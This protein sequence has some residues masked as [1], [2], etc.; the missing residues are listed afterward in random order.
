MD[1]NNKAYPTYKHLD[2]LERFIADF[3]KISEVNELLTNNIVTSMIERSVEYCRLKKDGLISGSMIGQ[4]GIGEISTMTI[5]EDSSGQPMKG[6]ILSLKQCGGFEPFYIDLIAKINKHSMG[7]EFKRSVIGDWATVSDPIAEAIFGQMLG[8]LYDMGICPFY[9]K[10]IGLYGCPGEEGKY[11]FS[12]ISEKNDINMFKLYQK[13]N[14]SLHHETIINSPDVLINILF[15]FIYATYIGKYYYGMTHHDTHMGNIMFKYINNETISLTGMTPSEYIYQGVNISDKKYFLMRVPEKDIGIEDDTRDKYVVIKNTGLLLKIIDYGIM[16]ASMDKSRVEKY[17]SYGINLGVDDDIVK[18]AR[19]E[20]LEES[21]KNLGDDETKYI[22]KDLD[23]L[24]SNIYMYMNYGLDINAY[25]PLSEYTQDK[26]NEAHARFSLLIDSLDNFARLYYGLNVS[27]K[28]L[29]L[30]TNNMQP[31]VSRDGKLKPSYTKRNDAGLRNNYFESIKSNNNNVNDFTKPEDLMH[32]LVNVCKQIGHTKVVWNNRCRFDPEEIVI[33]YLED[34]IGLVE[35][36]DDNNSMVFSPEIQKRIEKQNNLEKFLN[37]NEQVKSICS[38]EGNGSKACVNNIA[39]RDKY[40]PNNLVEK[41]LLS[42]LYDNALYDKDNRRLNKIDLDMLGT[43]FLIENNNLFK[44]YALQINPGALKMDKNEKGAMV[45]RYYQSWL[46]FKG[47]KDEWKDEYIQNVNINIVK[48]R[49]NTMSHLNYGKSIWAGKNELVKNG[50]NGFVVNGGYFIVPQNIN[51]LTDHIIDNTSLQYP[52]GFSYDKNHLGKSGTYLPI[53]NAY[54]KHFGVVYSMGGDVQ[55][56]D[57]DR[58]LSYHQKS[59]M[60]T[61]ELTVD[62]TARNITQEVILMSGGGAKTGVPIISD[63][64]NASY[65]YAFCVGPALIRGGEVVFDNDVM[66][67]DTF[68]NEDGVKYVV[69]PTAQSNNM[70]RSNDGEANMAYGMRHSNRFMVH[71][72][73]A[74][75]NNGDILFFLIEGRGYDAPGLDRVQAAYLVNKFNVMEAYSM[76]GGFSA[77]V[78]Y[79]DSNDNGFKYLLRDPEKRR[80]GVSVVFHN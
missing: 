25:T 7:A 9:N 60:T 22:T 18:N 33:Y 8:H 51:M 80:L 47:V 15:Q 55:V 64:T 4:G 59:Y 67:Q 46:D 27:M 62:G 6:M 56:M 41:R 12:I 32:G 26:A 2:N 79:R 54:R 76:D 17:R 44:I 20:Q 68:E 72:I 21:L 50:K 38:S 74:R 71:N 11:N 75:D 66:L 1:L 35:S 10:F 16:T 48:I 31:G 77:N 70:F 57:Y 43:N 78:V 69:M 58:F 42:R 34:E 45:Y 13:E 53:P 19:P 73:I 52:I 63:G 61:K 24:M 49:K 39:I 5:T 40:D 28:D 3:F 29:L 23:F 30:A 36:L 14:G 37:S 65:D